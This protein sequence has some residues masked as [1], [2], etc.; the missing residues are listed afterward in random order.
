MR[1]K[2]ERDYDISSSIESAYPAHNA[3]H[4]GNLE[5]LSLLILEGHCS[6]NQ[7]DTAGSTPAHKGCIGPSTN[8]N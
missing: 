7:K 4:N 5:L 6:V 8:L 2:K 3:A 1:E